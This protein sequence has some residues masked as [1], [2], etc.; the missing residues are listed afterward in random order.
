MRSRLRVAAQRAYVLFGLGVSLTLPARAVDAQ[1]TVTPQMEA[2]VRYNAPYIVEE[3]TNDGSLRHSLINHLLRVDFDGD[4]QGIN[5]GTNIDNDY[6]VH[7]EPVVYYTI[8]ETGSGPD[9]GFYYIGYYFYHA[10]DGGWK[11]SAYTDHGHD[12][13]L[14][15]V[16]LVVR[17]DS[18]HPYGILELAWSQAHGAMIPYA[19]STYVDMGATLGNNSAGY[20]G[21]KIHDY[22]DSSFG[23]NRPVVMVSLDTHA[24]YV[25]QSCSGVDNGKSFSYY[26]PGGYDWTSSTSTVL[27]ACV[28]D[29]AGS[30]LLYVPAV[31]NNNPYGSPDYAANGTYSYQLLDLASS[32]IWTDRQT[33]HDLLGGNLIN[34]GYGLSGYDAF[35][36]GYGSD[37]CANP[38]YQWQGGPGDR[39][40][41]GPLNGHWYYF[42]QDGTT[43]YTSWDG[44]WGA[45]SYGQLLVDPELAANDDFP[46]YY[47]W[48][49]NAFTNFY[50]PPVVFNEFRQ[51]DSAPRCCALGA[52]I[53]GPETVEAG[54]PTTYT[55]YVSGGAPPYR[56]QWSGAGSGTGTSVTVTTYNETDLFLDVWDAAGAHMAVST[57]LLISC[58]NGAMC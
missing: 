3:T 25:A 48:R 9:E 50:Q 21:G 39:H 24:T 41:L 11:I 44:P 6:L 29:W 37:C 32:P 13:D 33:Y 22:F 16:Y 1:S 27:Y 45:W 58:Q 49:G 28:H 47:D 52:S 31:D 5:N 38:P 20:W 10:K 26:E 7:R 2:I 14:E 23:V 36:P 43:N 8:S 4:L 18:Y 46:G 56:Y 40:G 57:H 53:N 15:G 42:S 34:L 30:F 54:T 51:P 17:K 12:H 35:Q 19:D 55:A